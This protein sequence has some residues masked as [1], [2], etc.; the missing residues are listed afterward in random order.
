MSKKRGQAAI[1]MVMA[2]V[3]LLLGALFFY[4]QRASLEKAEPIS[5][6]I[7]PVK[8]FI[9]ACISD[10][11]AQAITIIGMNGGY[12]TFPDR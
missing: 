10:A 7:A 4:A 11:A 5:P 1:F 12:I 9:D 8:R 3:I 2:I 6:E